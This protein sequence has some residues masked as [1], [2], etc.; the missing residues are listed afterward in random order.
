MKHDPLFFPS[1]LLFFFPYRYVVEEM[2]QSTEYDH[3]E[4]YRC[5]SLWSHDKDEPMP[6]YIWRMRNPKVRRRRVWGRRRMNEC[7]A[8]ACV[9]VFW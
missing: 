2:I 9:L 1:F 7:V 6:G 8:G 3:S 4:W 5:T